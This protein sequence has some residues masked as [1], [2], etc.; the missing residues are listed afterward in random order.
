MQEKPNDAMTWKYFKHWLDLC[1]EN[2]Y[3]TGGMPSQRA[4]NAEL[5]YFR[6]C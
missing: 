4:S 6:C 1:E 3:V 2:P 5:L